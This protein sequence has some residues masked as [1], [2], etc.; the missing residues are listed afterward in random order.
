MGVSDPRLTERL[1]DEL[2]KKLL[3]T[4]RVAQPEDGPRS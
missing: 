3:S 4:A 2:E 1:L